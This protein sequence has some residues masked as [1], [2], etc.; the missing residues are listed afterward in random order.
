MLDPVTMNEIRNASEVFAAE[1]EDRD[2]F[3][4]GETDCLV[5]GAIGN[6]RQISELRARPGFARLHQH[7]VSEIVSLQGFGES[8]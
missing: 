7:V 6:D 1:V 8:L 4:D 5:L 3:E 2:G